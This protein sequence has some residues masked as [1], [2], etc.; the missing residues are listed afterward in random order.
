MSAP[1]WPKCSSF[2]N[3]LPDEMMTSLDIEMEATELI[4]LICDQ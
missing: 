3:E 1:K 2:K 4:Y